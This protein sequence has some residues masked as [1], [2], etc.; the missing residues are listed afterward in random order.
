MNV[1][2]I[3]AASTLD[4]SVKERLIALVRE[5]DNAISENLSATNQMHHCKMG[6]NE[7]Q[8][9]KRLSESAPG[10]KRDELVMTQLAWRNEFANSVYRAQ[11]AQ[12]ATQFYG[13][14][15]HQQIQAL[16]TSDASVR[17]AVVALKM[18][19]DH[20]VFAGAD[21]PNAVVR[22][23]QNVAD[24]TQE[25]I[26]DAVRELFQ[27]K[28]S[29]EG[30]YASINFS[31]QP[32]ITTPQDSVEQQALWSATQDAIVLFYALRAASSEV[33]EAKGKLN[34]PQFVERMEKALAANDLPKFESIRCEQH[35]LEAAV[36]VAANHFLALLSEYQTA[37]DAFAAV[38][39]TAAKSLTDSRGNKNLVSASNCMAAWHWLHEMRMQLDIAWRHHDPREVLKQLDFNVD[40]YMAM[41]CVS[42]VK[43]R[44]CVPLC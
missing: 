21:K 15:L 17:T 44:S 24:I 18:V 9:A 2:N 42:E 10:A 36:F 29:G 8:Y 12:R 11:G 3:V 31:S 20:C 26:E 1:S 34:V 28:M 41:R 7:R 33:R 22:E 4:S 32:I 38:I 37:I 16:D 6:L 27:Q 43:T 13:K 23:L 14:E 35:T 30:K 40:V 25:K 19:I 39:D 5:I